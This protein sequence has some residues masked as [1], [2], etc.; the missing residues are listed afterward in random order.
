M[1]RPTVRL[2]D[3][4][5][6]SPC[7]VS[8]DSMSGGERVRYCGEC[9]L[10]VYDLSA[11][12]RR[13]AEALV[14]STEGRLCARLYRRPDGTLMTA[15]CPAG[16]R[17]VKRRASRVAGAALA[18]VLGL[19][20]TPAAGQSSSSSSQKKQQQEDCRKQIDLRR[21]RQKPGAS[22][23]RAPLSGTIYD[24]AGAVIAGASVTLTDEKTK[25]QHSATT[26]DNG[27]FRF[28]A[29]AAGDYALAVAA[30][31]FKELNFPKIAL[32]QDEAVSFDAVLEVD[33]AMT[34]GVIVMDYHD[35]QERVLKIEGIRIRYDE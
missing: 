23:K 20:G 25:Q 14:A 35:P 8:W 26:D 4:R 22:D 15:D 30:P 1:N 28:A 5:V 29:L 11:L 33:G 3:L 31:N 6:A 32:A 10:H 18:A 12:T 9:R 19:F 7:P 24:P 16:W 2:E 13:E 21:E 34:M 17:A 27:V